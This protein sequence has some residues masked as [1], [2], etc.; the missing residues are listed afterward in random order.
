MAGKKEDALLRFR[1]N[2]PVQDES[3][4]EW[5]RSQAHLSMSLRLLIKEDISRNGMSDVTCRSVTVRKARTSE[6]K[7]EDS[8]LKEETHSPAPVKRTEPDRTP[9]A[10][11]LPSSQLDSSDFP[12]PAAAEK[13]GNSPPS[14]A[15][16]R[17]A[18]AMGLLDD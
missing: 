16:G 1:L 3:V 18:F 2:V 6:P 13:T 7:A 4:V 8:V 12:L 11:V 5:I 17:N 14:G 9:P 15:K 10:P